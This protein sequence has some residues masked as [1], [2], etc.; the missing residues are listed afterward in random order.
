MPGSVKKPNCMTY[1]LRSLFHEVDLKLEEKPRTTLRSL[2][3]TL[4]VERH[5][6]EKAV[7][8]KKGISF[9]VFRQEKILERAIHLLR[10][11]GHLSIKQIG[12]LVGY[13]SAAAFSRFIKAET[14]KT[15]SEIRLRDRRM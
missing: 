1:D 12:Y 11:Q 7:R 10:E 5:T 2:C 15:A 8:S 6:I 13:Q 9:R 3:L 4:G 14:G